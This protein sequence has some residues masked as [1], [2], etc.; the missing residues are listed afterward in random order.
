MSASEDEIQKVWDESG[1]VRLIGVDMSN[2]CRLAARIIDLER[3]LDQWRLLVARDPRPL[4][5]VSP[6]ERAEKALVGLEAEIVFFPPV[7]KAVANAIREAV[8]EERE[9]C[10][11]EVDQPGDGLTG[12]AAAHRI[13]ARP[14]P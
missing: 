2:E 11:K 7:E 10:A 13:R 8:L 12:L 1:V 5:I 6:E 14:A 3:K 9:A 4:S